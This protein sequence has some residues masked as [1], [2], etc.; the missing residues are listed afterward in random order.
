MKIRSIQ[1]ERF[2]RLKFVDFN[3]SDINVLIGGNNSGKSTVIQAV[4]FAFTLIQSL[5][6][7]DKWPAHRTKS[8]TISPLDLIY[9]PSDDPYSLGSG[10]RLLEDDNKSIVVNFTFD[11]GD[12]LSL[13]IR[14][15]RI[16]NI[17]VER[18]N[19]EFAKGLSSLDSPYSIFSPGLAGVLGPKATCPTASCY[20]RSRAGMPISCCA[21]YC[22]A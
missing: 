5:S 4:H 7:A 10:G 6:I 9:I 20:V 18:T 14:K 1:I 2:K 8:S 21:T 22:I 11:T 13:R 16:T 17:I 19:I 12:E 15:G 3:V